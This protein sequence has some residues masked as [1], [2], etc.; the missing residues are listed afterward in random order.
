[1]VV[2]RLGCVNVRHQGFSL[3]M[4]TS[5][6]SICLW[7]SISEA[8]ISNVPALVPA[9]DDYE[10][11]SSSALSVVGGG[12]K[13]LFRKSLDL[14]VKAMF[15]EP[16]G[17]LVVLKTWMVAKVVPLDKWLYKP[18]HA[19]ILGTSRSLVLIDDLNGILDVRKTCVVLAER[20]WKSFENTETS[21]C[22]VD[23]DWISFMY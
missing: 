4:K 9:Y 5:S 17:M 1:M 18:R 15:L 10:I 14:E 8:I 2:F 22:L 21:N 12:V 20:R 19:R 6:H 23:I 7:L 11:F 16:S 13:V 3:E